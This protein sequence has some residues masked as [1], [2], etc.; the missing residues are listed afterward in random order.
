VQD[1]FVQLSN[2][3]YCEVTKWFCQARASVMLSKR[4]GSCVVVAESMFADTPVAIL[5]DA[6]LGSRAFINDET[7]RFLDEATLARDLTEFVKH[8]DAYHPRAWA[9]RNISCYRSSQILNDA[10]KQQALAEGQQWTL[11]LAPLQ[12]APEPMPAQ[13]EDRV[14]LA[15]EREEIRRRF[16]LEIG[17]GQIQ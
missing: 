6:E 12:W 7:G 9:E 1:R 11:D 17:L 3:P 8:A 2:Q 15:G 5:R 16:G 10:L 13:V 4:E 14:R